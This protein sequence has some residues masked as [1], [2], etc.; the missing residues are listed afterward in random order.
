MKDQGP[1]G[2]ELQL[3]KNRLIKSKKM[4]MQTSDA[5]VG[6]HEYR[7]LYYPDSVWTIEDWFKEVSAVTADE[8][9][10]VA[11]RYLTKDNWYLTVTGDLDNA[12]LQSIQISL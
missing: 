9:K 8:V 10:Q 5:W 4:S 2:E 7:T 11:N 12:F 1:T 6:W 3:V